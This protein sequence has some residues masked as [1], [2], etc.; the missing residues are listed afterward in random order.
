MKISKMQVSFGNYGI[1]TRKE[2]EVTSVF[3]IVRKKWIVMNAEE[4][5]RQVWIHMLVYDLHI[6]P[7]KISIEK[8]F[9]INDRLKR[10]DI[11]VYNKM[12]MPELLI[13]CKAPTQKIV[14]STIDQIS[15]YNIHLKCS[16]FVV[17]TGIDHLGFVYRGNQISI[18]KNMTELL[19]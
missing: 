13:E 12:A 11:C 3:D 16:K 8:G 6:S 10:F 14:P 18:V 19:A 15:L 4:Q 5:V 9:R 2:N 1:K 7:S 17:T